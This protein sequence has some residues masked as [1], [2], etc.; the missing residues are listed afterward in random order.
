MG[1]GEP[2]KCPYCQQTHRT[3][4]GVNGKTKSI[5]CV[6][7]VKRSPEYVALYGPMYEC[8]QCGRI[9]PETLRRSRL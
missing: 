5:R 1:D 8:S 9:D 2:V 3:V 6:R 7:E 4:E